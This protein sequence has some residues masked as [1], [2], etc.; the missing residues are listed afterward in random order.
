MS[1]CALVSSIYTFIR[2]YKNHVTSLS[3]LI[4]ECLIIFVSIVPPDLPS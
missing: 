1:L 3:N 2:G 4:L